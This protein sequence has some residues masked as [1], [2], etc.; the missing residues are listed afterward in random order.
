VSAALR[1]AVSSFT[2]QVGQDLAALASARGLGTDRTAGDVE[3]EALA[4]V[5][6]FIDADTDHSDEQLEGYLD[7]LRTLRPGRLS[8]TSADGLRVASVLSGRRARLTEPGQLFS[9]LLSADRADDGARAWRYLKAAVALGHTVAA[10]DLQTS[11]AELDAIE[12]FR[13]VLLEA[14]G[15]AG[16]P[17]PAQRQPDG[18]FFVAGPPRRVVQPL[19]TASAVE[20]LLALQADPP[21]PGMRGGVAG[22]TP[23][24]ERPGALSPPPSGERPGAPSPPSGAE[25]RGGAAPSVGGDEQDAVDPARDLEEVLGELESL[26]GLAPV[27]SEVERVADLLRVQSLR[28]RRGLPTLPVSR[29]LVFTGNPGT[30]KTTV[31]RLVAEIYRALGVLRSGHLV[32]TDRAGLVAGY[33]G[34]TAERTSQVV[35]E[36]LDGVLLIDEAYALSRNEGGQDY[37]R[38]AIDTLV[39]LMEDHRERLVVI[40]TGYPE[41]MATFIDAN[42][43]LASRFPR[44]IHFPDYD[45]DELAAIAEHLATTHHYRLESS[46]RSLLAEQL[47]RQVGRRGF[48]NARSVRNLFEAAVGRQA[49]RLVDVEAPTD[50]QLVVLTVEDV[51]SALADHRLDAEAQ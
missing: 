9:L 25:G 31:A 6:A 39:K 26:I 40:V 35:A 32:E 23:G 5:E 38:E 1:D 15:S 42:P 2:R 14:M 13:R 28:A 48:G 24:G 27:K 33:V 44:T 17:P 21:A 29:H 8:R 12:R 43:G 34:Q 46:A 20:E 37:G 51:R 41:E 49:S 3:E 22:P 7:L 11:R 18:G 30:G 10:L 4:L 19:A 45:G 16:V 36:A 47:A 50:D